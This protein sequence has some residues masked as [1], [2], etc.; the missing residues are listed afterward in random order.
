VG[1][2]WRP[3]AVEVVDAVALESVRRSR[4]YWAG[5]CCAGGA[6]YIVFP[7]DEEELVE[8]VVVRE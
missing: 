8:P 6:E 1:A 3:G 7:G 5:C 2:R 4:L